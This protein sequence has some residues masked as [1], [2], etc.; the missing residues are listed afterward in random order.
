MTP[1]QLYRNLLRNVRKLPK[2]S[3]SHYRHYIRQNFNSH[4]DE[5]DPERIKQI[6]SKAIQD[7]Q[8]LLEK[9]K[10]K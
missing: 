1:V 9:Y 7:M 4:T 2:E 5:T 8:W 3:Q 6:M 10:V